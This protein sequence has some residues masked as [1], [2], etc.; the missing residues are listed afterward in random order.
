MEKRIE[1]TGVTGNMDLRKGGSTMSSN[2]QV[3]ILA[4][5]DKFG[6]WTVEAFCGH[7]TIYFKEVHNREEMLNTLEYCKRRLSKFNP[8]TEI[9]HYNEDLG[10]VED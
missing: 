5:E 6:E 4:L 2:K 9:L 3:Q 7:H 10:Y 8:V 1:K